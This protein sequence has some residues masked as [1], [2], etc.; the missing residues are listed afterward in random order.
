MLYVPWTLAI[1]SVPSTLAPIQLVTWQPYCITGFAEVVGVLLGLAL[2]LWFGHKWM[3]LGIILLA[4]GGTGICS[5]ALQSHGK[6][7]TRF[8]SLGNPAFWAGTAG[9]ATRAPS[10]TRAGLKPDCCSLSACFFRSCGSVN[11]SIRGPD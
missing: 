5:C 10:Q 4:G 6:N 3:A 1:G 8:P 7:L 11:D 2:I 9:L